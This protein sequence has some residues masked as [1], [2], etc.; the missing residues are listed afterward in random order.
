MAGQ[1]IRHGQTHNFGP[2]NALLVLAFKSGFQFETS[3]GDKEKI[4]ESYYDWLS[5]NSYRFANTRIAYLGGAS[6]GGALVTRLGR[7]IRERHLDLPLKIYISTI[8]GHV[9]IRHYRSEY[10]LCSTTDEVSNPLN[11]DRTAFFARLDMYFPVTLRTNLFVFN[12]VSGNDKRALKTYCSGTSERE[13]GESEQ[14]TEHWNFFRQ[15]WVNVDHQD[16][17]EKWLPYAYEPQMEWF[18][19]RAFGEDFVCIE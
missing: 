4:V 16:I 11:P 9:T 2:N 18:F 17:C 19:H 12:T 3:V 5:R 15:V 10:E 6:R 13:A 8:D 7:R 14:E 1:I